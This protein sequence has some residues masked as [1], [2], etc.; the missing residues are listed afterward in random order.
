MNNENKFLFRR[1]YI[2]S[3]KSIDKLKNWKKIKLSNDLFLTSHPDLEITK[4]NHKNNDLVLLGYILDPNS[5][6][7]NNQKILE[8]I[9]RNV[10]HADDVFDQLYIMG[11]RYVLFVKINDALRLLNDAN[12]FR[13]IFYYYNEHKVWVASQP[14]IIAEQCN[15]QIDNLIYNDLSRLTLFKN[16]NEYWFPITLTLYKEI[17]HLIP[18]HYLDLKNGKVHRFWPLKQRK[19]ISINECIENCSFILKNLL[20][21]AS[22][23]FNLALAITSGLDSRVILAA[24]KDIKKKVYYLTHTHKKLDEKGQDIIIPKEIANYFN[25]N[26]HVAYHYDKLDKDFEDFFIRNV[27]SARLDKSITVYAIYKHF[28]KINKRM[29]LVN[30]EIGGIAKSIFNLPSFVK[31]NGKALASLTFMSGSNIIKNEYDRW[32]ENIK[33]IKKYGFNILD[34]LY[35]EGR[36]ANWSAMESSEYDIGYDKWQLPEIDYDREHELNMLHIV[37]ESYLFHIENI[38]KRQSNK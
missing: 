17:F 23:R 31:L 11:G 15:L 9:I 18:N 35:W 20:V 36:M 26:H 21:A 10:T 22:N 2:I 29:L 14:S 1:Q 32:L 3:N 37:L 6:N 8:D 25:L 16:T 34:I 24:C 4:V 28:E 12:G 13:Q 30:G 38:G 19:K 33:K 7:A 5:P 27:T